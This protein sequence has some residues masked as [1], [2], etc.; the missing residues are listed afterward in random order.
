MCPPLK[1]NSIEKGSM[2]TIGN[3]PY[4][5]AISSAKQVPALEQ[6][7]VKKVSKSRCCFDGCKKKLTLTD[8]P[9]RCGETHCPMHRASELHNCS[10]DYK[11]DF[12][13]VLLKTM[14]VAIVANK[15]D[16]I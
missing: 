15:V 13:K 5:Q 10:Y 8:F 16:K 1:S 12:R 11:K 7:E 3:S 2:T 9:C 14:D 6:P 4:L